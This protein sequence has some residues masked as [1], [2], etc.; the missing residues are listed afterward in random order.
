M[1]T[2]EKHLENIENNMDSI[3]KNI[4]TI[5][6][7]TLDDVKELNEKLLETDVIFEEIKYQE[8]QN[9]KI[10]GM[11]FNLDFNGVELPDS[12]VSIIQNHFQPLI[13]NFTIKN[14]VSIP[15]GQRESFSSLESKLSFIDSYLK[16]LI[17]IFLRNF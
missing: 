2:I 13:P 8:E 5:N 9:Q 17:P 15:K 3:E 12:F 11:S 1:N 14:Y 7:I 16:I 4:N 10:K 6:E